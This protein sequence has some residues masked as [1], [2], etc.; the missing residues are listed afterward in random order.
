L[1]ILTVLLYLLL[2]LLALLLVI[3]LFILLIPFRYRAQAGYDQKPWFD[4]WVRCS[5][6]FIFKGTWD[7][8]H[9][10]PF[11]FKFI[12]FGIPISINHKK[13]G[14]K[15]QAEKEEKEPGKKRSKTLSSIFDQ[16]LRRSGLA[17]AADFLNILKPDLLYLKGK[18]GFDEP[19][20]TGWLVALTNSFKYS[21]R[22]TFIA[23][24][25]VWEDEFYEFEVLIEG[26]LKVG[27]ILV[28]VGWFFFK[29][30]TR[31]FFKGSLKNKVASA[32]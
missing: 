20:L 25:P 3:V 19:H 4:F 11:K 2:I 21:C 24:E 32:A 9:G 30:H 7:E 22:K 1:I 18:I 17:L 16:D 12:L 28:K 8:R 15:D 31:H 5:P 6:A 26:R 27:L 14:E 29:L 13:A 23:L 10:K